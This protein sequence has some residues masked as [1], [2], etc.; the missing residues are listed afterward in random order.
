VDFRDYFLVN[1]FDGQNLFRLFHKFGCKLIRA[2]NLLYT[3]IQEIYALDKFLCISL[4]ENVK[5]VTIQGIV[6][7]T[8]N[9]FEIINEDKCI[10]VV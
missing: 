2:E 7:N 6:I 4:S 5:E 10:T 9:K 3:L 8:L 1:E